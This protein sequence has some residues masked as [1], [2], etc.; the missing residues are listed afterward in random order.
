MHPDPTDPMGIFKPYT[1]GA[2]SAGRGAYRGLLSAAQRDEKAVEAISEE[3][4]VQAWSK[5]EG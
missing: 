2:C 4:A 5:L 3:T 1:W